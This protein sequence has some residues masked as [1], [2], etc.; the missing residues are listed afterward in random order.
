MTSLAVPASSP[1]QRPFSRTSLAVPASSP[2][3]K[4]FSRTGLAVPASSPASGPFQGLALQFLPPV[5]ASGPFQ[6]LA[7][8]FLPPVLARSPFQG[9]ALQFL[10]PVQ[11]TMLTDLSDHSFVQQDTGPVQ[12]FA[13]TQVFRLKTLRRRS[14]DQSW[15]SRKRMLRRLETQSRNLSIESVTSLPNI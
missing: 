1:C 2:C 5:L 12:L 3:Q 14:C 10:P 15:S 8:H 9:L 11:K 7:S 4:T 13:S 6:G